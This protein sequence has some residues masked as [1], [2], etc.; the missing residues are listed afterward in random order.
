MS[1]LYITAQGSISG[2]EDHSQLADWKL[3]QSRDGV[4]EVPPCLWSGSLWSLSRGRRAGRH[5]SQGVLSTGHIPPCSP[6]PT[7]STPATLTPIS[8][9][10]LWHSL[11]PL[12]VTLSS[13]LP[14]PLVNTLKSAT[15]FT[16][17]PLGCSPRP[18]ARQTLG[19]QAGGRE[20]GRLG[21]LR[22]PGKEPQPLRTHPP[23]SLCTVLLT[24]SQAS[25]MLPGA[26][27]TTGATGSN[28]IDQGARHIAR[29]PSCWALRGRAWVHSG[30]KRDR[31]G[32]CTLPK[33]IHPET[34]E[35]R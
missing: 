7:T 31:E 18:E 16:R 28:H 33:A 10:G 34:S 12:T 14:A 27:N 13:P 30:A 6:S 35:Q 19:L 4:P 11:G 32:P 22:G 8:Y 24:P 5:S 29:N 25:P 26:P 20:E 1:S 9:P 21:V 15:S 3:R 23:S 2:R 17:T